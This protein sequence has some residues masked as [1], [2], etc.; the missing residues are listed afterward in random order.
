MLNEEYAEAI[1]NSYVEANWYVDGYK[2]ALHYGISALLIFIFWKGKSL[3]R[4][5]KLHYAYFNFILLFYSF[6]NF[7]SSIPSAGRFMSP[8]SS[9]AI[10]LI[11]LISVSDD[12]RSRW[13]IDKLKVTS[14]F[15]VVFIV[16]TI[17]IGFDIIGVSTVFG[18]PI[19]STFI[20]TDKPLMQFI[21]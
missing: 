12:F 19:L 9:M 7:T 15:F 2:D 17:R 13:L 16:V 10:S 8:A 18:N 3:L 4:Q 6:A 20:D 21:K 11:L 14:L 1:T 5:E